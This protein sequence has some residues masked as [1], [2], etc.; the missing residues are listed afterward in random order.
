MR[1]IFAFII[2]WIRLLAVGTAIGVLFI[3]CSLFEKM[4]NQ[5]KLGIGISLSAYVVALID[6]LLGFVFVGWSSWL[7]FAFAPMLSI[8]FLICWG[9]WKI[10]VST[11]SE[12]AEY[13]VKVCKDLGQWL[14]LD[15]IAVQVILLAFATVYNRMLVVW[16]QL[17]A[18]AL[19]E[20]NRL[21]LLCFGTLALTCVAGTALLIKK[22]VKQGCFSK[23]LM[24]VMLL[25]FLCC[26]CY[27][28]ASL[29]SCPNLGSDRAHY[30][31]NARYFQED[32]NSFEL[33]N[34]TDEHA[35]SSLRDDHG[36]LWTMYLADSLIAADA[37]DVSQ[38]SRMANFAVFWVYLCFYFL[39]FLSSAYIAGTWR[40]GL[41][42][43]L[44]FGLYE[45]D[46]LTQGSRDAFRFIGL[47]LLLLY[48][49][50]IFFRLTQDRAKC[51]HHVFLLLFCYISING[52]EGNVYLM[53]GMFC[54][55]GIA[56]LVYKA[57]WKQL[58][59]CASSILVGTVLGI[60][61]T[62]SLYLTT[63]SITSSTLLPF[64]GTAVVQQ[65]AQ[66][67]ESRGDWITILQSY[68]RPIL[69]EITLG[70]VA[71]FIMLFVL[72]KEK[73]KEPFIYVLLMLGMLLPLTKVMD[74]IGYEC[75][76]WFIQQLRYRMYFLMLFAISGGWLLGRKWEKE[77]LQKVV[78]VGVALTFC[79]Y[80]RVEWHRY[81]SYGKAYVKSCVSIT[82]SYR[83]LDENISEI[84]DGDV[85]TNNEV[86]LAHLSGNPKLLFHMY[87][88]ELIQAKTEEEIETA[89]TNLNVGAILLPPDGLDYHDYSLLPFWGYIN[90]S[91]KVL[92]LLPSERNDGVP[93]TIYICNVK[94]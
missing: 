49:G 12:I 20:Y 16:R 63:G 27:L 62:I 86:L 67:N 60:S 73:H 87:A 47:L 50:D 34:Y 66:V 61:K 23:H 44:L 22:M 6:Y 48:S 8:L 93:Y 79:M 15:L 3:Q 68:S 83:K 17:L 24:I 53:L 84:T 52:H 7:Y 46:M 90:Q 65:I 88:E 80:L 69:C 71:F 70:I 58:I 10:A 35:G 56:L 91:D 40:A 26:T 74:W 1:L 36:P 30:E 43:L 45:Y 77:Q 64:H 76:R 21:G 31:L 29:N 4:G 42:T 85:F 51:R 75:S 5:Q 28:G 55:M 2:Y 72:K 14:V 94:S 54:V 19:H 13:L 33:D 32:K 57:P 39:L 89:F 18:S 37:L 92:R 11:C 82:E 25:S 81:I 38:P 59:P 9:N 41:V 78:T